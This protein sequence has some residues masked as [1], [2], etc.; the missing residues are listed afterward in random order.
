VVPTGLLFA[1][2]AAASFGVSGSIAKGLME[3]GWTPG[4]AVLVRVVIAALV[5]AVPGALAMR[6]RWHVLRSSIGSVIAYG[7]FAVAGAQLFYFMA[8]STLD[9][10]VALLIEYLAPV[11]VV[12]WLWLR[13]AQRPNRFTAIGGALAA[14][15]L[16]LLLNVTSGGPINLVGIGWALAAMVGATVY[17]VISGDD[18]NPLPPISLA[19]GGLLIAALALG[20]AA[21]CG[22]LPLAFGTGDVVFTNFSVPVWAAVLFLGVVTAAL[23]YVTGI[24]ATRR[25]GAR[26]GSFVALSEVV[27]ATAFAWLLLGQAPAPIQFGGAALVLLGVVI[28]KLAERPAAVAAPVSA[29]F[30]EPVPA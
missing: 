14:V 17:F 13:H 21:A 10:G 29:P 9:V 24:A 3:N 1:L 19:A 8:V 12:M 16:V 11:A 23:A 6:G 15:G 27:A 18:S 28:V 4:A 7:L 20:I 5:L 22:V 30:A 25:L 2:V 26:V